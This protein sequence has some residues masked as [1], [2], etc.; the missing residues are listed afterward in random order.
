MPA[1]VLSHTAVVSREF[2]IPAVVGTGDATRRIKT[3]DHIRV[4]G[5]TGVVEFLKL[6]SNY[7]TGA[8][9]VRAG[10]PFP[11]R[12]ANT[13]PRLVFLGRSAC[14]LLSVIN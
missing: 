5:F 9:P 4:N 12:A 6:Q 7:H 13:L 14:T 2:G 10:C 11:K 1:V 8:P 3:G